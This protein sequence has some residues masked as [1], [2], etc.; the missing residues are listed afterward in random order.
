[1]FNPE[2]MLGSLLMGGMRR[3]RGL[4]GLLSGGAALGLVGVAMEAAE[5]YLKTTGRSGGLPPATP[6]GVPPG[7][8]P[9][10]TA[11]AG[12]KPPPPPPGATPTRAPEPPPAASGSGTVVLLIR[13]MVA[14]ANADGII[15]EAERSRIM[16][17]LDAARL[18]PEEHRFMVDEIIHPR[19]AEEIVAGAAAANQAGADVQGV[20][21]AR[22]VYLVSLLAVEVDTPQERAYL[23]HLAGL[24]GLDAATVTDLHKAAG[25]V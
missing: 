10:S 23:E 22:Q 25:V 9:I 21:L 8:P 19:T 11:P 4:G 17:K 12:A 24:L 14:A 3:Q 5:H 16:A 13:A 18:S 1:M 6:G 7:P 2:K 20:E 15:D